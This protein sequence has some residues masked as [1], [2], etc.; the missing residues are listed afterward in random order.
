MFSCIRF[1]PSKGAVRPD[2]LPSLRKGRPAKP[3]SWAV[4]IKTSRQHCFYCGGWAS[5]EQAARY[6]D[7]ARHY[8]IAEQMLDARFVEY[9]FPDVP[10]DESSVGFSLKQFVAKNK[11]II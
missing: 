3:D 10:Y 5:K 11:I 7:T 2:Y 1:V 4:V 6:A 8:L 9:N